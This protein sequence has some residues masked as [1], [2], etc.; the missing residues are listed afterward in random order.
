M[1]EITKKALSLI[2]KVEADRGFALSWYINESDIAEEALCRA[3]EQHEAYKQEVSDAVESYFCGVCPPHY[4][5]A[6]FII[7]KPTVDPLV[8][9]VNEVIYAQPHGDI[10]EARMAADIREALAKRGLK[11][12]EDV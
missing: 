12:V 3:I 8:R 9:V 4:I 11:I 1:N 5:L 6:R 10:D 7:P 2:N